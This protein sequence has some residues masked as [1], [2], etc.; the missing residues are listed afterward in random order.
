MGYNSLSLTALLDNYAEELLTVEDNRLVSV[1]MGPERR[2]TGNAQFYGQ[3]LLTS[4]EFPEYVPI[5][6]LAADYFGASIYIGWTGSIIMQPTYAVL[7]RIWCVNPLPVRCT[8][9]TEVV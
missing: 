1:M 7:A 5:S 4:T 3:I 8:I 6:I 2:G 9:L